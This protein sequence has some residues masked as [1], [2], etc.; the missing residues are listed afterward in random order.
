MTTSSI[1]TTAPQNLHNAVPPHSAPARVTQSITQSNKPSII[2]QSLNTAFSGTSHCENCNGSPK[3]SA[4]PDEA[5]IQNTS[6]NGTDQDKK[7]K[8][9]EQDKKRKEAQ[10]N[11]GL[12]FC[13]DDI[14]MVVRMIQQ[15]SF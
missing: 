3:T 2:Q 10:C 5:A 12:S 4:C 9:L 15:A 7:K 13:E 14:Q 11:L 8:R 1:T 6:S